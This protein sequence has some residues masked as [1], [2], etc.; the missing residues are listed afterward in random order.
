MDTALGLRSLRGV[1]EN[2]A[3][4]NFSTFK[5][6]GPARYFFGAK[7]AEDMVAALEAANA[8]NVPVFVLGGG[9]NVLIA[10]RG[11]A[12]LVIHDENVG[13]H[14]DGC[15]AHC[16]SGLSTMDV[17]TL[18]AVLNL[19][20]MEFMAGIPGTVGAAVRGNA[21][22]WGQAFGELVKDVELYR[23]GRREHVASQDLRFSYRSS[24][25]RQ[26]PWVVLGAI[27]EL[28]P[29]E[30]TTIDAETAKI[31]ADRQ[32]RLPSDPSIGS[33]FKNIEL[34]STLVDVPRLLRALDC[35]PDEYR[36]KTKHGK[37]PVGLLAE[38]LH[39]RGRRIGGAQIS[40]KHGNIIINPQGQATAADVVQ[41][42]SL[43]K[44]KIRDQ[45]GIQLEEEIQYIGF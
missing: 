35:P 8:A 14:V 41:L 38:R 1:Q 34:N 9:S 7:T 33:I 24:L 18:A 31:V 40:H 30:R 12:G 36:E 23:E 19:G 42:I 45:L 29:R 13:F 17:L 43:L 10:D 39:M 15:L 20:G 11:F 2:I 3:L 44:T 4:K 5:I 37:L 22:A 26:K 27:V 32:A 25:L 16:G 21:G 28:T 6:G